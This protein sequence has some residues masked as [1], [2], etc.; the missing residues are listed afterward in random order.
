[1]RSKISFRLLASVCAV[2]FGVIS[3]C[4]SPELDETACRSATYEGDVILKTQNDIIKFANTCYT[5]VDGMLQIGAFVSTDPNAITDL[6][7]LRSIVRANSVHIVNNQSLSSLS[8]LENIKN[9]SESILVYGNPKIRSLSV[10]RNITNDH[11]ALTIYENESLTGLEGLQGIR[12]FHNVDIV[13]NKSLI[14][15]YA[16]ENAT[17]MSCLYIENNKTLTSLSGLENVEHVNCIYIWSN[18]VL[19]DF[20]GI[21]QLFQRESA[22]LEFQCESNAFNV[23]A[24][25]LHEGRCTIF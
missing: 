3:G 22:Q 14:D 20:C 2:A 8:G 4:S 1:M 23:S 19:T 18:P 7:P 5:G 9:I 10:F 6:T 12:E 13:N 24:E 11:V 25:D 17:R 21:A 16:L 15:L